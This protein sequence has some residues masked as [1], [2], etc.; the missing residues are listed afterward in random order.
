T[1]NEILATRNRREE[2]LWQQLTDKDN[3]LN[4]I[5]RQ[6]ENEQKKQ[7]EDT[8]RTYLLA[9]LSLLQDV[10]RTSSKWTKE[11]QTIM[12]QAFDNVYQKFLSQ[13]PNE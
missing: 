6:R 9:K 7:Q 1:Q 11:F 3:Q 4:S 10:P 5:N 8:F 2:T 12:D 13:Q